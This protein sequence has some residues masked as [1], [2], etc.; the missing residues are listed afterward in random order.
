MKRNLNF[1]LSAKCNKI[2]VAGASIYLAETKAIPKRTTLKYKCYGG[3]AASICKNAEI[4]LNF[5]ISILQHTRRN[6]VKH[7][8][9]YYILTKFIILHILAQ[10]SMTAVKSVEVVSISCLQERQ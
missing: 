9:L 4:S 7:R 10:S 1:A 2:K 5:C 3:R 8:N 6:W